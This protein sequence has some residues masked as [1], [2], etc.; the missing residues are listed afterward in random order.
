MQQELKKSMLFKVRAACCCF[1]IPGKWHGLYE[2]DGSLYKNF[3]DD[4][5]A[6]GTCSCT[7]YDQEEGDE[8]REPSYSKWKKQ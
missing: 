6:Y 8:N 4:L 2:G 1:C 5:F 3:L 7:G